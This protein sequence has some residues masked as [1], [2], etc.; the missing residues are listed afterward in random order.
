VKLS[1]ILEKDLHPEREWIFYVSDWVARKNE[2][3]SDMDIG[4]RSLKVDRELKG[5]L[6]QGPIGLTVGQKVSNTNTSGSPLRGHV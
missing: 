6:C 3:K 5:S 1:K 4:L 2:R